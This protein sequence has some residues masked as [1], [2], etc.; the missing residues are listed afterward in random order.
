MNAYDLTRQFIEV[1]GDIDA[2][3]EKKSKVASAAEDKLLD[4]K[5][6]VLENKM[7]DIKNKLKDTEI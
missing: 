5:I 2:L 1:L 6:T 3:I 7:F 4:D